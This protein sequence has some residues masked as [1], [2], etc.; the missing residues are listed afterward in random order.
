M[1]EI[2]N[3][4]LDFQYPELV[5]KIDDILKST[6][7]HGKHVVF[8][9]SEPVMMTDIPHA[10][11]RMHQLRV[12]GCRLFMDNFGTSYASLTYLKKFPVDVLK[13]DKSFVQD[14][15]IDNE[16]E[17]I[18]HS[19]LS[20]AHSLGIQCVGDGIEGQAQMKFLRLLGCDYFQGTLFSEPVVGER[21]DALLEFGWQQRF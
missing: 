16:H 17:V 11:E 5:S 21:V 12:L 4:P 3:S 7:V 6:Q 13:I 20:L 10:L 15:G 1:G 14:I 18:I 19:I 2:S 8:E 9:I